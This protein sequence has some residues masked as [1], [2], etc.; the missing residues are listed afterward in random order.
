MKDNITILI[1]GA[2]EKASA[3]AWGYTPMDIKEF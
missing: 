2:G 3:V 1:K